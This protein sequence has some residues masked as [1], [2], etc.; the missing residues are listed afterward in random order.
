[1]LTCF[2]FIIPLVCKKILQMENLEMWKS[3][4]WKIYLKGSNYKTTQNV[5]STWRCVSVSRQ[6]SGKNS[7]EWASSLKRKGFNN[8]LFFC[9]C[10]KWIQV[11]VKK[12]PTK[13][14]LFI[15]KKEGDA[16]K[17]QKRTESL[18]PYPPPPPR[19][20]ALRQIWWLPLFV[21]GKERKEFM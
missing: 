12:K 4:T 17:A 2:L 20:L 8:S 10:E 11:K 19:Q 6:I 15:N 1:M 7:L 13:P 16:C 14:E 21:S 18:K 9:Q 3:L 5:P